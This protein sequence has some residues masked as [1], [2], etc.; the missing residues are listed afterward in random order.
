MIGRVD[1]TN[2]KFQLNIQNSYSQTNLI[3]VSRIYGGLIGEVVLSRDS[4]INITYSYFLVPLLAVEFFPGSGGLIGSINLNGG[5]LLF[6]FVIFYPKVNFYGSCNVDCSSF[7][8]FTSYDLL[9]EFSEDLINSFPC[10]IWNN[11]SLV[12]QFSTSKSN[13]CLH[14]SLTPSSLNPTEIPSTLNPTEIPSTLIPSQIPSTLNPT[15]IPSTLIPSIDPPSNNPSTISPSTNDPSTISPSTNQPSTS[16]PFTNNP[17]TISSSPSSVTTS[18]YTS[19]STIIPSTLIPSTL[20]PSTLIPSTL[21]PSTL[22]PST[23]LPSTISPSTQTPLNEGCLYQVPNCSLCGKKGLFIS[24]PSN[25]N[26]SCELSS[27]GQYNYLISSLSNT[28]NLGGQSI[29][30]N[31]TTTI[32][33]NFIQA[34]NSSLNFVVSSDRN[35]TL[36]VSSCVLINGSLNVVL[37]GQLNDGDTS[38]QLVSYNCSSPLNI[39]DSQVSVTPNYQN[40][41]CDQIKSSLQNKPNSLSVVVSSTLNKNCKKS[42][43]KKII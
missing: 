19:D 24:D 12:N 35:V 2:Q 39:S 43:K 3:N 14:R 20:I 5:Y 34:S 8:G 31:S 1:D 38:F 36:D 37:N 10:S 16:N 26:I 18:T 33:G 11:I 13:N 42:K 9:P 25:F 15:E 22:I 27:N 4:T 28:I 21:I 6:N 30:I 17:S 29:T 41:Q 40:S 23:D 7:K 32:N